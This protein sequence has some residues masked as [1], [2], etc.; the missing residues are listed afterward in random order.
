VRSLLLPQRTFGRSG[1]LARLDQLVSAIANAKKPVVPSHAAFSTSLNAFFRSLDTSGSFGK[2][3][4]RT[5]IC[6]CS[7]GVF[8]CAWRKLSE[9]VPQNGLVFRNPIGYGEIPI[10]PGSGH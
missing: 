5:C 1:L 10:A 3:C 8:C 9:S 2:R 6:N 7:A 4:T